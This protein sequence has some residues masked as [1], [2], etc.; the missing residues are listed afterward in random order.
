MPTRMTTEEEYMHAAELESQFAELNGYFSLC[1]RVKFRRNLQRYLVVVLEICRSVYFRAQYARKP[2]ILGC[3]RRYWVE[4]GRGVHLMVF[5]TVKGGD[6]IQI[7]PPTH[8]EARSGI[9]VRPVVISCFVE[10]WLCRFKDYWNCHC[11]S[12]L[13]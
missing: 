9:R 6:N 11:F 13:Y 10:Q 8:R 7:T 12:S 3:S 5:V 4:G 1:V 2:K